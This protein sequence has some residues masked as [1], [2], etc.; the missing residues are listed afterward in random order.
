MH[1]V[2]FSGTFCFGHKITYENS[3]QTPVQSMQLRSMIYL[4]HSL[5]TEL[6][7]FCCGG[8]FPRFK[9]LS[10]KVGL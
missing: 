1:T 2:L 8:V 5:N 6:N 3:V 7:C 9:H 4:Q 10:A